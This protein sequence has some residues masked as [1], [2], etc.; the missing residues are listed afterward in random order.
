MLRRVNDIKRLRLSLGLSVRDVATKMGIPAP[1]YCKIEKAKS[2]TDETLHKVGGALGLPVTE[3]VVW[4][5][6]EK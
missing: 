6:D 1:T 4:M 2:P 5:D 3:L